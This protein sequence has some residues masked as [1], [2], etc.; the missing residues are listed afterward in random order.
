MENIRL[1][2]CIKTSTF[3]YRRHAFLSARPSFSGTMWWMATNTSTGVKAGPI[4][5]EP[6]HEQIL[7]LSNFCWLG[8][9]EGENKITL[10]ICVCARA[11][12]G[13]K[14]YHTAKWIKCEVM[15]NKQMKHNL[16]ISILDWNSDWT[17]AWDKQSIALDA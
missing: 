4:W 17:S 2:S 5:A 6:C 16:I 8:V 7:T 1:A 12:M 9:G 14:C 10:Y 11:H 15:R 3:K 13:S